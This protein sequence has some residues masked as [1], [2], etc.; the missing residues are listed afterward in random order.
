MGHAGGESKGSGL[1][2]AGG[3]GGASTPPECWWL[4]GLW[5]GLHQGLDL[6]VYVRRHGLSHAG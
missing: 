6:V 4:Q 5:L 1:G 3:R 2:V